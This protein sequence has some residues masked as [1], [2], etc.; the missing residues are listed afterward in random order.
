[1]AYLFFKVVRCPLI[2]FLNS[3]KNCEEIA[4]T[5]AIYSESFLGKGRPY[6]FILSQSTITCLRASAFFA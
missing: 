6:Y 4:Q 2:L 3:A 1:M 5:S